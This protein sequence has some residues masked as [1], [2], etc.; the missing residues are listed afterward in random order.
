MVRR[1]ATFGMVGIAAALTHFAVAASLLRFVPAGPGTG[2]VLLANACGFVVAFFVSYHGQRRWTFRSSRPHGQSLPRYL[3]V[4]VTGLAINEAVVALVLRQF[5]VLPVVALAAGIGV[6]AVW[7][8][9]VS[10]SWVFSTAESAG[11]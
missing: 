5:A 4:S 6:A 7:T 8:F 10:R 11:A 9:A 1:L 3:A 2:P